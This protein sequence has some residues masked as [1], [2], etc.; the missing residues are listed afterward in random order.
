[1]GVPITSPEGAAHVSVRV[2]NARGQVVATLHDGPLTPG[3][4]MLRWN[5]RDSR[6]RDAGSGIYWIVA[7]GGG[8][9]HAMRVVQLR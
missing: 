9:R 1:V 7:E 3:A 6:S 5:G 4:R 8:E 2:Y